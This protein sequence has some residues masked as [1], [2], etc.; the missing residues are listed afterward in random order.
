MSASMTDATFLDWITDGAGAAALGAVV[1]DL[2]SGSVAIS[3]NM[4][5]ADFTPDIVTSVEMPGYAQQTAIG[6][7]SPVRGDD[8][9]WQVRSDPILFSGSTVPPSPLSVSGIFVRITAGTTLVLAGEFDDAIT[10]QRSGQFVQVVVVIRENAT[11]TL[12]V[13]AS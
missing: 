2:Y 4:V 5:T 11:V 7:G 6:F 12:E 10:V 13:A 9:L 3:R 1:A 8:G